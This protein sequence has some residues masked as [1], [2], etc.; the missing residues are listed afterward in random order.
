VG[1]RG[2]K[3]V[4]T[5]L[6]FL[7]PTCPVCETLLPTL[8]RVVI[9]ESDRLRLLLASDGDTPE[10]HRAFVEERGLE[11]V[12]YLLSNELGMAYEVARLPTA[13]LIDD[14]GIVRARGLVNSR[15]HLES[16][17]LA[18]DLGVATIQEHLERQPPAAKPKPERGSKARG[19]SDGKPK[20][21][22][23]KREDAAVISLQDIAARRD[24]PK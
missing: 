24:Q 23:G 17:F 12:P 6:F 3:G 22:D 21:K 7:S 19:E 16:L 2:E 10:V 11:G 8:Q 5:L 13:V 9:D 4:R 15:E 1:G 14:A 18:D 20:G